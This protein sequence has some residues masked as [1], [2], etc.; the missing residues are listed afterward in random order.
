M[1]AVVFCIEVW[2]VLCTQ[3]ETLETSAGEFFVGALDELADGHLALHDVLLFDQGVLYG[4]VTISVIP[5]P[6]WQLRLVST[7]VYG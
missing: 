7:W 4:H 6:E 5:V 3:F 2:C 1:L